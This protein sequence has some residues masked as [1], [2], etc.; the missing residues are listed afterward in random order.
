MGADR[1]S[2]VRAI[3]CWLAIVAM[4]SGLVTARPLS[5]DENA[6]PDE[7]DGGGRT[8]LTI[9]VPSFRGLEPRLQLTYDARAG[10]DWI[11]VGWSL[12]GMSEIQRVGPGKGAPT[13][14]AND[15]F[16]L[17][18]QELV[19][20][21]AA[22]ASPGCQHPSDPTNT[23]RRRYATKIERFQRIEFEPG[24][25]GGLWTIWSRDGIK[26]T[27]RPRVAVGWPGSIQDPFSWH[28]AAVE[29]PLGNRVAYNYGAS[30]DADGIG[31]QYLTRILYNGTLISFH[32]Q[33]RT[34]VVTE[35]TGVG[36]LMSRRRL[37]RIDVATGG[38]LIRTYK[39]DYQPDDPT[40][41]GRSLL[42]T[43]R[44][45]GRDAQFGPNGSVSAGTALS[46][47]TMDTA[48]PGAGPV[49]A[50]TTETGKDELWGPPWPDNGFTG[51]SNWDNE[52]ADP[53]V[54]RFS[55]IFWRQWFPGDIDGDGRTDH[56]GVT[57]ERSPPTDQMQPF[58]IFLHAAMPNRDGTRLITQTGTGRYNYR[59]TTQSTG[60]VWRGSDPTYQF[61]HAFAGDVNGDGRGDVVIVRLQSGTSNVWA[62]SFLSVGDGRF[63]TRPPQQIQVN[64]HLRNR[65]FLADANGDRRSDLLFAAIHPACDQGTA[66]VPGCTPGRTFEH[67]ALQTGLSHGDGTWDFRPVQDTG[68]NILEADDAHWFAADVNGDGRADIQRLVGHGSHCKQFPPQSPPCAAGI[69][70][71]NFDH[72]GIKTAFSRGD[73]QFDLDRSG[74]PSCVTCP[75]EADI[76]VPWA[77]WRRAIPWHD[78]RIG[79]DLVHIGDMDGDGRSD[80]VIAGKYTNG[81]EYVRLTTAFSRGDGTYRTVSDLTRLSAKHLNFWWAER[82]DTYN[83]NR[84]MTGDW[85]GDGATDLVVASPDNFDAGPAQWPLTVAL[86]RLL[87]DR[88]GKYALEQPPP[89]PFYFDCWERTPGSN[90]TE[91]PNCP[92]DLSF[93]AYMG[94]VNGDG[95]DDFMYAGG[96]FSEDMQLTHFQ[97]QL[98]P[99]ASEGTHRWRPGDVNGDGRQDL[100]Y[101]QYTRAGIR[102]HTLLR[103]RDGSWDHKSEPVMAFMYNP[104]AR[105]WLVA[106]VGSVEGGPDG[107]ADLVYVHYYDD[108]GTGIRLYTLLSQGDGTWALRYRNGEWP[109]FLTHDTG[110]WRPADIDADGDADL[111]HVFSTRVTNLGAADSAIRV[112][113]MRSNGDGDWTPHCRDGPTSPACRDAWPTFGEA[114]TL[115]WQPMDVNGDGRSDLVHLNGTGSQFLVRTLLAQEDGTWRIGVNAP[116]GSANLSDTRGWRVV[117]LNGDGKA[118]LVHLN[119]TGGTLRTVALLGRG[120]G[121]F[122]PRADPAWPGFGGTDTRRWLSADLNADGATDLV[123]LDSLGPG[124]QVRT[125]LARPNG[126]FAKHAPDPDT[127]SGL[128]APDVLNW[129]PADAGGDGRDDLVRVE[130][131]KSKLRVRV[132]HATAP[133]DLVTSIDNGVGNRTEVTYK[134][135]SNF[136]PRNRPTA[137]VTG[138]HLPHGSVV[139]LPAVVVQR[140]QGV[141]AD[142]QTFDYTCARWSYTERRLLGWAQTA[143]EHAAT[144]NRPAQVTVQRYELDDT[145]LSRP[146]E[147]RLEDA[148]GQLYTRSLTEY[149][150]TGPSPPAV[151]LPKRVHVW[152]HNGGLVGQETETTMSYDAFGNLEQVNGLGDPADL[153]D[154]QVVRR[155]FNPA[156]G[157]WIVSLP[158][159]EDLRDGPET[160]ARGYRRTAWCYDGENGSSPYGNCPGIPTKGLVTAVKRLH[161]DGRYRTSSFGYDAVGNQL[162]ATDPRGNTT[163][164]TYDPIRQILPE[165][166]CNQRK[167]CITMEWDRNQ[168]QLRVI[169]D[170][171]GART[172]RTP[173]DLGRLHTTLRP[174][175]GLLTYSY[176]DWDDHSRRRIRESV[177]DGTP[178]GLW[179]ETW[180]DGLDRPW[181]LVREG[182][183]PG[184]TFVQHIFYTDSSSR[185]GARSNWTTLPAGNPPV[186]ERFDYDAAGRLVTQTHADGTGRHWAYGNDAT[187]T[188]VEETDERKNNKRLVSD[189]HGRLAE[190]QE[191]E[192][193]RISKVTYGYDAADQLRTVTDD[194]GNL[195]THTY[196]LLGKLNRTEDPDLGRWTWTWDLAGNIDTQTD[197]RGRQLRFTYDELNRPKTKRYQDGTAVSWHYDE[198][199]HGAGIGR[200][201][202]IAEP[203]GK[204]CPNNRS[205]SMTY[206]TAGRVTRDT[207]CVTGM[208]RTMRFEFDQLDRHKAV[209][210]PDGTRQT[211]G[212][213]SAGRLRDMPGLV[214]EFQYD[215]DGH[216]TKAERADSTITSWTWDPERRWLNEITT[217][218]PVTGPLL[219]LRYTHEPNGLLKTTANSPGGPNLSYTYDGLD[220]LTD[221]SGDLTQHFRWDTIGNLTSSSTV[222]T[223]SYPASGP[224]GCTRNGNRVPCRGPHAASRAG[225]ETYDYDANGN[226]SAIRRTAARSTTKA[227]AHKQYLVRAKQ[228]GKRRDTLW[229]IAADHLGDP[230]RWPEIFVLNKGRRYPKPPGGRFNSPHWIYPGQRLLMP[231]TAVGLPTVAVPAASA[232]AAV[233]RLVW[234]DD[235]RLIGIQGPSGKPLRMRY[236]SDG[237]RVE[238]Q[239]GNQVTRYFGPWLEQITS[240]R[241][242]GPTKYYWAGATLIARRDRRGLNF[243]HQDDLGS[244][245]MLTSDEGKVGARYTYQSFGA[246]L[247]HTG[248]ATTDVRFT[249]QR[250]DESSLILMGA[251]YYDPT[252]ARFMSP[253]TALPNPAFTQAA[254]RY[255]YAYGNPLR[256]TDPTGH[257]PE[258]SVCEF[259]EDVTDDGVGSDPSEWAP[260][261][262]DDGIDDLS[263]PPLVEAK[264][265]VLQMD[266]IEIKGV[267]RM[268]PIAIKGVMRMDPIEIKGSPSGGSE[269]EAAP[270]SEYWDPEIFVWFSIE[271]K[272]EKDISIGKERTL[273]LEAMAERIDIFGAHR[274]GPYRAVV[275]AAGGSIGI[276]GAKRAGYGAVYG[277]QEDIIQYSRGPAGWTSKEEREVIALVEGGYGPLLSGAYQ[278]H[279]TTTDTG[280]YFGVR[281]GPF[282]AGFGFNI[283][284]LKWFIGPLLGPE[285][286]PWYDTPDQW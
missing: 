45:Y 211:Y 172:E 41:S 200:L 77:S 183:Q 157:P 101:P 207:R 192:G 131:E 128:D 86:T 51:S 212:Y 256:W 68:W 223:Y 276:K 37:A 203:I 16:L 165:R 244:T 247:K 162:S 132:L 32:T 27:Y 120:D 23:V 243:Y 88:H 226:T 231:G 74:R 135:S 31:Q 229:A 122:T 58:F 21:V 264:G 176:L 147:T 210:Y 138:C 234:N 261:S 104:V 140:T 98:A 9:V 257:Q 166:V 123:H 251:R 90:P 2:A 18:G 34:D 280:S 136:G 154:D 269:P 205:R 224:T 142:R 239:V 52:T 156:T 49:G 235:N 111:I 94:D 143:T 158:A 262:E 151:C 118:D 66:D 216:M 225:N 59:Y 76:E 271:W 80:L 242:R 38:E 110:N 119:V 26:R 137:G 50:F 134:P 191:R 202:S 282:G 75:L 283:D 240:G 186:L 187:R 153:G 260:W 144:F 179:S 155:R 7:S 206:D 273:Q 70:S 268:D 169:V 201:T 141:Q 89:L 284:L 174:G 263:A 55:R 57:V 236:D 115:N 30:G 28:L 85:N 82:G 160:T 125:L 83:P 167:Q 163:T 4:M 35:A 249:S 72:F 190:V 6:Q 219:K 189:A 208:A 15:R 112:H 270:T 33:S 25:L 213:D 266:P 246:P 267:M 285:G 278:T 255:A 124:L 105:D 10:N 152:Q 173:D 217:A 65:W 109:N 281:A 168:G 84:W 180:L 20:C 61:F 87:S 48:T 14:S 185:P 5:G 79:S 250:H 238:K 265:Q 19:P 274:A 170:P 60:I 161:D 286:N 22:S 164:T 121:K 218:S 73:G 29:D 253:D 159:S 237:N 53:N 46:P 93:T 222:G 195:T 36:L 43:V 44:Q 54:A 148:A 178:D 24:P 62:H 146:I 184:R 96:K 220:R 39:L 196:D 171:N 275:G 272:R 129:H 126:T 108:N 64:W 194:L 117:N 227:T 139:Q 114:D 67:A 1:H 81:G 149:V 182:D 254:N 150:P 198:P 56:I 209:I 252:R 214:G 63:E 95:Q 102:V 113:V 181:R 232:K 248:A 204:G 197:A 99:N 279:P 17:D 91:P 175:R 127:W 259:E 8:D 103:R 78:Q 133:T 233:R 199:G 130:Y 177:E 40:G 3:G 215:A 193:T 221:V 100:I 228:R 145:C 241:S 230:R 47:V 13:Y 258:C 69:A 97:V 92:N 116:V 11:G 188:W 106:D 42:R 107:R 245:R 12:T 71:V 277:G